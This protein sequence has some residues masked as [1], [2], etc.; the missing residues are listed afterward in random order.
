MLT[1][2]DEAVTA[3]CAQMLLKIVTVREERLGKVHTSTAESHHILGLLYRYTKN[4]PKAKEYTEMALSLFMQTVGE[5]HPSTKVV[6]NSLVFF[7][8]ASIFQ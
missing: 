5:D 8:N 7:E 6:K 4:Y 3:E 1:S 2:T